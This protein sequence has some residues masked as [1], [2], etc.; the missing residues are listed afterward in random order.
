MKWKATGILQHTL[1]FTIIVLLY[2]ADS[3]NNLKDGL[4]IGVIMEDR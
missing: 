3:N 2:M 4:G 1:G